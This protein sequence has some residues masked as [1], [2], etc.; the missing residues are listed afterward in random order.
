MGASSQVFA[1]NGRGRNGSVIHLSEALDLFRTRFHFYSFRPTGTGQ[2]IRTLD[3]LC[4]NIRTL[5]PCSMHRRASWS[6]FRKPRVYSSMN[7]PIRGVNSAY[8]RGDT[9]LCLMMNALPLL[10]CEFYTVCMG[11][12]SISTSLHRCACV[13]LYI[14]TCQSRIGWGMENGIRSTISPANLLV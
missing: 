9:V 10:P 12:V 3:A 11:E 1:R 7:A 8:C 13:C 6:S 14:W 5:P 2:R 4:Y